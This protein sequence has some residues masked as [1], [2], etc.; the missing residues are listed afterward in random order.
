MRSVVVPL[1]TFSASLPVCAHATSK[2]NPTTHAQ[3]QVDDRPRRPCTLRTA[4][5]FDK[6]Q[7]SLLRHEKLAARLNEI[8][9]LEKHSPIY[10]HRQT[11]NCMKKTEGCP[12]KNRLPP[13]VCNCNC[14]FMETVTTAGIGSHGKNRPHD[15]KKWRQSVASSEPHPAF[16]ILL[17]TS[18]PICE[19]QCSA[20]RDQHIGIAR[21]IR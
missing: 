10:F 11:T 21:R 19:N 16:R 12:K 7:H 3:A 5:E 8:R 14:N 18:K 6:P 2:S 20:A 13:A 17:V 1:P 9:N 15:F 4:C